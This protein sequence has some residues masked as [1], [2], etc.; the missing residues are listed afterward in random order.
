L[1]IL[2]IQ[3]AFIGD[4]IL[5][6]SLIEKLIFFY[7][8]AE[9]DFLV[10]RG[11]ESL[12]KGHP[13]IGECLVFD[14]S[15][16]KYTN[17]FRIIRKI[18]SK[19]Y[20]YVLN[21]QR[22]FTTGLITV[23]SGA[24]YKI[25]YDKNPLSFLFSSKVKHEI[26]EKNYAHEINRNQ[27]LIQTITNEGA[28]MPKLYPSADDFNKVKVYKSSA[29]IC[30]APTSVWYTKQFPL[31]RW[32]DFINQLDESIQIYLLG[33]PSDAQVCEKIIRTTSH[34][35]IL[36]LA[37]KLSLLASAALMKDSEMNYVNDSAPMHLA[38]AMNA[39]VCAIY[40]STVPSFGFGPLS[41]NAHV[42]EVEEKLDCRPCGLHGYPTCPKGHF[43]CANKINI[44]KLVAIMS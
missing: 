12:L 29:Y 6:T 31:N 36:N 33:A 10:R 32:I 44:D 3:T 15:K 24:K 11:N 34:K 2:I 20:T 23:L 1:K 41:T 25:G 14:K 13:F 16:A 27:L 26:G 22:F 7:P 43:N 28:E 37:G 8:N 39:P 21:A 42:V 9:I 19:K 35:L 30:I 4:V 40:C 18:R 17:L 38:S 5:A